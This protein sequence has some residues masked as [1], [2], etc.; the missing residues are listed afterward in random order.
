MK[1]F[2]PLLTVG[3]VFLSACAP[4]SPSAQHGQPSGGHKQGNTEA[5]NLVVRDWSTDTEIVFSVEDDGKTFTDYG[6]SHTKEMHLIVVR[7]DL[8]HFQHLH[9]ER[10]A[11]GIWRIPFG[12]PAGG[13]YWIYADF[14]EKNELPHTIRIERTLSGNRGAEGINKNFENVK[15]VDGYRIAF[16]PSVSGE[17]VTFRYDITNI[18]GDKPHLEEYLG[19]I[20]HSVL[21][22]PSG[23]FIHTHASGERE[24]P[25][26]IT[27]PPRDPFYR[28]FTQFQINGKV[29]TVDFDWQ[30]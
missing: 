10:D 20:G 22:S 1:Y 6:I 29:L 23:D 21:I 8:Q 24:E 14:I 9:P 28:A 13:T 26:F 2:L 17:E 16:H 5:S 12:T 11:D 4:T 7:N 27:A 3:S 18:N 15:T 19:A 30:P 25:M